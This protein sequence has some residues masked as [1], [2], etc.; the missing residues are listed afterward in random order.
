MN[1]RS[2]TRL[3]ALIPLLVLAIGIALPAP[4]DDVALADQ[5]AQ[6]LLAACP[7][8]GPDD[9]KAR[10]ASAGRLTRSIFLRERMSEPFFWGPHRRGGG[11]DPADSS[12]TRFNPLVWRRMYLSLLM[13]EPGYR[14]EQVGS[15]TLLHIPV[16]FRNSL[17]PGSYPYPFWHSSRKWESWQ[18]TTEILFLLEEGRVLGAY[19]SEQEDRK[20]SFVP[21]RWDGHWQWTSPSGET[22]PRASLYTY[23]FSPQN[24]HVGRLETAYR[25]LEAEARARSCFVCHSPSNSA[26]MNPLRLLNYPNQALTERHAVV[27]QLEENLMPPN[28]GI[29]DEAERQKLLALAQEFAATGDQALDY[30]GE[31]K[32][33]DRQ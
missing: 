28:E 17:D 12:L 8:A 20:R 31:F 27:Q 1:Y 5:L 21:R 24:P 33:P 11:Y 6:E 4:S 14:I 25:A 23:L 29:V 9:E 22:L 3:A 13:F 15:L 7:I 2:T 19:R 10:D 32:L 18:F 26:D 16:R 30:E